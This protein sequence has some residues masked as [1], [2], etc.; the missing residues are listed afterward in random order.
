MNIAKE[1]EN[2]IKQY[3]KNK[4]NIELIKPYKG[5]IGFDFR[6]KDS[7]I[8]IEVKGTSKNRLSDVMFITFTNAEYE[9]AKECIRKKLNYEIHLVLGI[10]TKSIKHYCI[11][12]K[13]FIE[14]AKPE[15]FWN[16]STTKELEKFN[17]SY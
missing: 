12:A 15:V 6:G 14:K 4:K 9:K 3:F 5:E 13:T 10:E 8:F 17:I 1:A 11:P 7:K 2:Y 16:L